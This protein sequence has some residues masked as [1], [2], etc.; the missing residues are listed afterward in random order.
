MH[1]DGRAGRHD[2]AVDH[3][4]DVRASGQDPRGGRVPAQGLLD[5]GL[6]VGQFL[7]SGD[8]DV[9]LDGE[10]GAG[11]GGEL[12]QG[13]WVAEEEPGRAGEERGGCFAARD[14]EDDVV[15]YNLALR[16]ASSVGVAGEEP[17]EVLSGRVGLE[18]GLHLVDCELGVLRPRFVDGGDVMYGAVQ[19][20]LDDR[21]H[22]RCHDHAADHLEAFEHVAHVLVVG[23]RGERAKGVVERQVTQDV[24]CG[25]VHPLD[26]VKGAAVCSFGELCHEQV[27]VLVYEWLLVF[28][29][30]RTEGV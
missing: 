15:L 11:F 6:E 30:L 21:E 22:G 13:V 12:A 27:K 16:H 9:L 2:A 29:C 10:G 23:C 28:E 5:D 25:A 24:K 8:A 4:V 7:A 1:A 26:N 18:S 14:E 3:R 19:C 17:H 20:G